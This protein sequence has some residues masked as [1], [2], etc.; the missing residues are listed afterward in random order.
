MVTNPGIYMW[1]T[2]NITEPSRFDQLVRTTMNDM[3]SGI[4]KVGSASKKFG[5]KE[6]NFTALQTLY[7]LGQCT[8]DLSGS[9]CNS[10]LQ[11]AIASLPG[12]C[13]GKQGGRVLFP[14]CNVRFEVYPFYQSSNTSAPTP[15]TPPVLVPPPPGSE[16]TSKGRVFS[17]LFFSLMTA[18]LKIKLKKVINES[19]CKIRCYF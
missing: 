2:I 15:S 3:A 10:C 16:T 4:S 1:N 12:C 6:A 11:R 9:D 19:K 8:P 7:T 18:T 13:G 17:H 14:S 5:A